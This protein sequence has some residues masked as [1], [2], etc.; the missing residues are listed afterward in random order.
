MDTVARH[1]TAD[2]RGHKPRILIVDDNEAFGRELRRALLDNSVAPSEVEFHV[3]TVTDKSNVAHHL[4]NDDVDI[5]FVDLRLREAVPYETD[6]MAMVE[7]LELITNIRTRAPS[8][9]VIVMTSVSSR[10]GNIETWMR[11]AHDYVH[12]S[13]EVAVARAKAL[14]LWRHIQDGRMLKGRSFRIGE[15]TFVPG[16]RILKRAS[17][18]S[19]KLSAKEYAL[20]R[21]LATAENHQI[22]RATFAAYGAGQGATD[23]DRSVDSVKKRLIKKLGDSVEIVQIRDEGYKL[24]SINEIQ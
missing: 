5:Y 22:D 17:G 24:I 6:E 1:R 14:T 20:L 23:D 2:A 18:E 13:E 11:G 8:A 4:D 16:N 21:H 15:W 9:G 19:A 10:C 12:K 7:G 3:E